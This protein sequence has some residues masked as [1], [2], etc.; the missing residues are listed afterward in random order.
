MN[1][2]QYLTDSV[3]AFRDWLAERFCGQPIDFAVPGAVAFTHLGSALAAYS[4]PPRA[5]AGL[6]NPHL[7]LPFVHPVVP[8]LTAQGSLAANTVVLDIIQRQLRT[9]Y[10]SGPRASNLLS[11]A[12]AAVLHWGGVYTRRGNGRWLSTNHPNLSAILQSVVKDHGRGEDTSTVAGLR[13]NSGMTKVYSLLI[14][15]FIIYDSRVAAS[16]AWLAKKWWT[17]DCGQPANTLPSLL[18]FVCLQGNGK[19]ASFRN[20]D[21]S[22][23]KTYATAAYTH[24]TWNIRANWLLVDALRVADTDSQFDSLREVES[25]LFQMGNR[26]I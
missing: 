8:V 26:V 24:Y 25:A 19:M 23:F 16:L 9:A 5:K 10:A 21:P 1:Q 2:T 14:D 11:G 4:W 15:D 22:L 3:A 13:F 7:G 6:P 12:V 18:R 20:P 17:I